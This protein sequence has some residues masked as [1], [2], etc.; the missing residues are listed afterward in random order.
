MNTSDR[1]SPADDHD[2]HLAPE[3]PPDQARHSDP[4]DN[5]ANYILRVL[6]YNPKDS[7]LMVPMRW[8]SGIDFNYARWPGKTVV[9]I[10]GLLLVYALLS[11]FW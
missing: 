9:I 11:A 6:Y 3:C 10:V 2:G 7:A 8:G 4:R 5:P 1:G